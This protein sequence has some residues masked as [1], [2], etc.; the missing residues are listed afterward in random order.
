MMTDSSLATPTIP[1]QCGR[2]KRRRRAARSPSSHSNAIRGAAYRYKRP[3]R[4]GARRG[5]PLHEA[6][7]TWCAAPLARPTRR[8]GY[9]VPRFSHVIVTRRNGCLWKD[10][11]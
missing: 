4:R 9:K 5:L 8:G 7:V 6:Y 1:L 11:R 3:M 2:P 10:G